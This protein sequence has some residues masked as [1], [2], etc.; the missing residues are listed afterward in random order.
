MVK[1][2]TITSKTEQHEKKVQR[3]MAEQLAEKIGT[4][5]E[6]IESGLKGFIEKSSESLGGM[7]LKPPYRRP[8]WYDD[9][10]SLIQERTIDN[11][12][13]EF[14][15]LNIV[16]GSEAYKLRAGLRFLGLID[17]KGHPTSKLAGL[18][19]TGENFKKNLAKVISEAYSDLFNAVIIE[20][21]K[22]ESVINFMIEKYGYS[23]PLAE[24]AATLFVYFCSK[25]GIPI[26]KE[27]SDFQITR[28]ESIRTTTPK[29][30]I[31]MR[32]KA[33]HAVKYDET[34]AV[35]ESDIFSFAVRKEL[36][37]IELAREQVN[38]LLDY[39]KKKLTEELTNK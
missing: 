2:R 32:E 11:F 16:S 37:A 33:T 8:S 30:E 23:R 29:K 27:L 15:R 7:E 10:L 22:A 39:W 24:E 6:E 17:E 19:V 9:F 1:K 4:S 3:K 36:S 13:L 18:R 28:R 20:K 14:I 26:S 34:F 25:A 5:P 38:S 12:S 35:L 21:A 31:R